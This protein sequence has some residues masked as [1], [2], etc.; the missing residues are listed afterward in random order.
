MAEKVSNAWADF[1]FLGMDGW[2]WCFIKYFASLAEPLKRLLRKNDRWNWLEEQET[3]FEAI[4]N[5]L[6]SAPILACSNFELSFVLQI[7]AISFGSGVLL[8]QVIEGEER[9]IVFASRT[10]WDVNVGIRLRNRNVWQ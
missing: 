2:Y 4:K 10:L 7:N 5:A 6:S 8:T 9:E 3:A 1:V